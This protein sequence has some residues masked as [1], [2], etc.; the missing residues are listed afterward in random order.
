MEAKPAMWER[1]RLLLDE[2]LVVLAM[3][4]PGEEAA[5]VG[6][7]ESRWWTAGVREAE[8]T[9]GSRQAPPWM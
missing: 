8:L 7:Y 1:V 4:P 6:V 9:R 2:V 5:E 3:L